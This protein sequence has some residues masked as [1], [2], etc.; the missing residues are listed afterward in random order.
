MKRKLITSLVVATVLLALNVSS[1]SAHVVVGPAEVKTATRQDFTVGVPNE[2]DIPTTQV[3]LVIPEGLE[4]VT[5]YVKPG[6]E[7]EMKRSGEGEEERVTEITW[8]G[9][10]VGVDLRDGFTFRAM[11]PADETTLIWKAYQTYSDGTVVSWD[12]EEEEEA[13]HGEEESTSGPYS[14]SRIVA[15]LSTDTSTA[16]TSE[17]RTTQYVAYGALLVAVIALALNFRGKTA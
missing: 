11:T 7:I 14:E 5:P 13:G 10:E 6:W 17:N 15:E 3:R 9:G 2:K 8:K 12:Q 4:S 1:I 16:E